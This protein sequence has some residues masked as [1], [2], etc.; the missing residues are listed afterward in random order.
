MSGPGIYTFRVHNAEQLYPMFQ[1]YINAVNTDAFVQ[2]ERERV[3]SAHSVSV[4]MGRT[5]G[6]NY[7]EP[8]PLMSRQLGNFHSEPS[9]TSASYP[10][11]ANDSQVDDSPPNLQSPVL[12]PSAY[13]DQPLRALQDCCLEGTASDLLSLKSRIRLTGV[14]NPSMHNTPSFSAT[15]WAASPAAAS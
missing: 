12:I 1:R 14:D 5:E 8:A 10:L 3:N 11:Q 9:S 4:N 6:N 13:L 7:L 15:P 2:G